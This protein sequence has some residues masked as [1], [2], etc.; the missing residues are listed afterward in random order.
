MSSQ[1]PPIPPAARK[2]LVVDDDAVVVKALSLKLA[3]KGFKV[4][5]AM[6]A[7]EAMQAVR[8]ETPDLLVLDIT[9][10]PDVGVS[11]DGFRI[12]EWLR[13]LNEAQT[14]PVIIITGSDLEKYRSRANS[15]GAAALF[16]KPINYDDLVDTI[17]KT[18]D[19][20]P[21]HQKT[22]GGS[23]TDPATDI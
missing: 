10:P 12:V 2:I 14:I 22:P 7:A 21:G 20:W 5:T 23:A 17:R 1:P 18:L 9:F 16:Q 4:V 19:E 13:R 11:W 8:K 3:S 15:I 6:D